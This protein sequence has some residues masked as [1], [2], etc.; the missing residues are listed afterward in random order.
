MAFGVM[1]VL[2]VG[3]TDGTLA[4]LVECPLS[5]QMNQ[6]KAGQMKHNGYEPSSLR[7]NQTCVKLPSEF[8][9]YAMQ[10]VQG[11]TS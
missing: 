1:F 5:L 3:S 10:R 4:T 7:R 9:N 11:Y 2:G 8:F 6:A